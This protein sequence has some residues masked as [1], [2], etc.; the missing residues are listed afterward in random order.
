MENKKYISC[1]N[2]K[3]IKQHIDREYSPFRV[4]ISLFTNSTIDLVLLHNNGFFLSSGLFSN[5]VVLWSRV[6]MNAMI[7][8]LYAMIY[9]IDKSSL[10][11]VAI[12]SKLFYWV[13]YY[14][15]LYNIFFKYGHTNSYK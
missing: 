13:K 4:N 8:D 11:V 14:H 12:I 3:N 10:Y 6:N 2:N 15:D 5:F 1:Q 7:I 9:A